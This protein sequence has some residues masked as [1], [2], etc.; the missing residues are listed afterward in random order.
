MDELTNGGEPIDLRDM[1][2]GI[3][4]RAGILT[5]GGVIVAGWLA[6]FALKTAGKLVRVLVGLIL[7]LV[8]GTFLSVEVNKAKRHFRDSDL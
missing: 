8:A 3:A 1:G 6:A 4:L 2:R 7:L 5:L